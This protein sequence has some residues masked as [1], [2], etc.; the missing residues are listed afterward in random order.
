VSMAC[1]ARDDSLS[2]YKLLERRGVRGLGSGECIIDIRF[3][4]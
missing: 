1:I 3:V 2:F 4:R